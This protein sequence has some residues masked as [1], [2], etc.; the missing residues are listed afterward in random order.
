M[1]YEIGAM[2]MYSS[3]NIVFER[4]KNGYLLTVISAVIKTVALWIIVLLVGKK[5]ITTPLTLL[6]EAN[7]SVDFEN[8][9]TFK[10]VHLGIQQREDELAILA[11]SFNKMIQRLASDR[12][13]LESDQSTA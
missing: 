7:K 10:E 12:H 5:L 8:V 3:S 6:T 9:E 11:E 2:T 4:V 13:A 1:T